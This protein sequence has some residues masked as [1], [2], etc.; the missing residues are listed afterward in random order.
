MSVQV[1][2]ELRWRQTVFFAFLF[3][4]QEESA[5]TWKVVINGSCTLA[6]II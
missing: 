5:S 4:N 3:A 2:R 1:N 6:T